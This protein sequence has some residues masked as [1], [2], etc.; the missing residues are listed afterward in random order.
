MPVFLLAVA[1]AL[2]TVGNVSGASAGPGDDPTA[3]E[4]ASDNEVGALLIAGLDSDDTQRSDALTDALRRAAE[5]RGLPLA[6]Q[7]S[8]PELRLMAGCVDNSPVCL[9]AAA[10]LVGGDTLLFGELAVG[11]D[12]AAI[13]QLSLLNVAEQAVVMETN[14]PLALS[15]LDA[16]SVDETAWAIMAELVPPAVP[17]ESLYPADEEALDSGVVTQ[18]EQRTGKRALVWGRYSPRPRWKWVLFGVS[19]GVTVVSVGGAVGLAASMPRLRA[20]VLEAARASEGGNEVSADSV[21]Q[22]C[23]DA[24]Q[25]PDGAASGVHNASIA[26]LCRNGDGRSVAISGLAIVGVV[27]GLTTVVST[28]LLFVHRDSSRATRI[29]PTFSPTFAG[30]RLEKNF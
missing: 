23:S 19:A 28:V 20:Q 7:T 8:L 13:L 16:G 29:S 25:T 1:L 24:R 15:K 30:L 21:D 10:T 11:S 14:T 2:S 6:T 18:P 4:V 26:T 9:A 3:A 12:G 27:S 17:T 22:A 5:V